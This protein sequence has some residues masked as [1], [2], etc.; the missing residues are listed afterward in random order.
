MTGF[1]FYQF[2]LKPGDACVW[3]GTTMLLLVSLV[4]GFITATVFAGENDLEVKT[5]LCKGLKPYNNLDEFLDQFS[6]QAV[7][8]CLFAMSAAELEEL[9]GIKILAGERRHPKNYYALSQTDFYYKPYR[10]ERDAFFVEIPIKINEQDENRFIVRIT[11]EYYEKYRSLYTDKDF[12]DIIRDFSNRR[13]AGTP[14]V[15]YWPRYK[16]SARI[17]VNPVGGMT[18]LVIAKPPFTHGE[19]IHTEK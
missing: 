14:Y 6:D 11:N 19:I 16:H 2:W 17:I 9:W 10:S 7:S 12:N 1:R 13:Q 5:A 3:L 4:F 15:Y 18:E 8:D